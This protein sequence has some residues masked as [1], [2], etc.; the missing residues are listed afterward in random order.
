MYVCMC[1]CVCV[2]SL[3]L[4]MGVSKKSGR[5]SKWQLL[6][7]ECCVNVQ[8]PWELELFVFLTYPYPWLAIVFQ[9]VPR[10]HKKLRMESI[11]EHLEC[12]NSVTP[13]NIFDIHGDAPTKI[14]SANGNKHSFQFWPDH[15][16]KAQR[17][18]N[19]MEAQIVSASSPAFPSDNILSFIRIFYPA[20]VQT[21]YLTF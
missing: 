18:G 21:F 17:I 2:E 20:S 19:I 9:G 4:Q 12:H 1:V 10:R 8:K 5:Y 3:R 11:R 14:A 13:L 6:R 7:I 15:D 16:Q